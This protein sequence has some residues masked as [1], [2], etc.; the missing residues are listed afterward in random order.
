MHLVFFILDV[1]LFI[2]VFEN[3]IFTIKSIELVIN[4]F[5]YNNT[6]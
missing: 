1:C 4:K 3:L 2:F 5:H 6:K